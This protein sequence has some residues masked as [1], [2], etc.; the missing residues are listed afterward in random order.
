MERY[1]LQVKGINKHF[2]GVQA[3]SDA[4]LE[5]LPGE[6]HA[7]LG[8][9]GA[10]KSTLIKIL[11]GIYQSDGGEIYFDGKLLE[12]LTVKTSHDVGISVI[13]QE[14][15]LVPHMTIGENIFMGRE[16]MS[17]F[18]PFV[19]YQTMNARAQGYLD[20]FELPLKATDLVS[21]LSVAEQQMVEICRAMSMDAKLIIMD[22][23]TASLTEKEVARLFVYIRELKKQNIAVVYVSHRLEE[24]F[25]VTDRISVYRDGRYITTYRTAEVERRD[26]VNSMVGRS[27]TE[28]YQT[29]VHVRGEPL[30]EVRNLEVPGI[31]K[32]ISFTLYK[33]E[34]LG[35]SGI[36]GAGR[37]EL[38]QALFGILPYSSGSVLLNGKAT[39]I[40][41]PSDAIAAGI[42]LVPE[43]RKEHGL[44]LHETV[45]FN[46]TLQVLRDFM[47]GC[48][49][50]RRTEKSIIEEA[51][52]NLAIR[53]AG[54]NQLALH[55]SG[56]NQQKVVIA[57][58]LALRP[59]ILILDE[60]TRG[61]DVG[62]KVEIY[63]IMNKLAK[64]G[65][66]IIMISSEL[67]E[68]L[69]MSD[70][71]LVM[72]EGKIT[73]ELGREEATPEKIMHFATGGTYD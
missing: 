16:P 52:K 25:A 17:P 28:F 49:V 37:T 46:L 38:A 4:S 50:D 15:V 65:V 70:R 72:H 36:V 43:S 53:T 64:S 57:K 22:E 30:L 32:N 45:G 40:R 7:L 26:L 73:G 61:I 23:P 56:G 69:N 13:H 39:T 62:A 55:L 67:P 29:E 60:P 59:Q 8:A 5:V 11:A 41:Q 24:L 42:G 14:L 20:L 58:W 44:N 47:R 6:C 10:G 48:F 3:L 31:L 63:Q 19:D 35:F 66:S 18:M 71:I 12:G 9:N 27:M 33:G 2:A 34:I 1:L 68:V 21:E 51:T 54:P